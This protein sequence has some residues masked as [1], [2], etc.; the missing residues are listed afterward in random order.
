MKKIVWAALLASVP[1]VCQA[2]H[3]GI[4]AI[5]LE[6]PNKKKLEHRV[7]V[8]MNELIRQV[9]NFSNTAANVNNPYLVMYSLN[10]AKTGWGIRLGAGY[11]TRSIANDDGISSTVSDINVLNLRLGFEKAFVLSNKWSAGVG[12]DGVYNAD[13]DNTK[14]T[15]AT[16]DS[17]ITTIKSNIS[18]YGGGAMAWLR[19]H[20][21]PKILIGTETSFYYR[22][23]DKKQ[24]ITIVNIPSAGIPSTSSSSVDNKIKEGTLALPVAFYLIVKF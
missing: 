22:T 18:S 11:S 6:M 19:Y 2:Q 13:K 1:V 9:F 5:T 3:E 21:T 24:D 8:Q 10:W 20:I 12:V 7:G 15:T 16:F 17:T 4:E 14:S 23:G